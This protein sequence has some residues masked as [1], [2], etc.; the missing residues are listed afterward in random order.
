M[1]LSSELAAD[2][3]SESDWLV[4]T[5][6]CF[7]IGGRHSR[8][9]RHGKPHPAR[10]VCRYKLLQSRT[11]VAFKPCS[12]PEGILVSTAR[13]SLRPI[14]AGAERDQVWEAESGRSDHPSSAKCGRGVRRFPHPDDSPRNT[15]RGHAAT[16]RRQ[17]NVGQE[18]MDQHRVFLL[19]YFCPKSSCRSLL[20]GRRQ[21][22]DSEL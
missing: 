11:L 16:E 2:V 15:Q 14:V 9:N 8:C 21:K 12:S 4:P 20:D 13:L 3:R 5:R 1:Q 19:G 10:A 18:D 7:D 6:Q 17:E 22:N